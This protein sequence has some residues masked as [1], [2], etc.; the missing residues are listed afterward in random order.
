[1]D[2]C[3]LGERIGA[4]PCSFPM[5]DPLRLEFFG[6]FLSK[7]KI[8]SY[9]ELYP[10]G[11]MY[12]IYGNIYHQYTPNVSIYT[13]HGSYGYINFQAKV[14]IFPPYQ[15]HAKFSRRRSLFKNAIYKGNPQKPDDGE[16]T[17]S[18]DFETIWWCPLS[19][20]TSEFSEIIL[21]IIYIYISM[22]FI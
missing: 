14:P 4:P 16:T 2:V 7:P 19:W 21:Y 8:Y 1:M 15:G 6:G 22:F 9:G 3:Q 17:E 5:G 18:S 11:S 10:I 20:G 12:A 13:I